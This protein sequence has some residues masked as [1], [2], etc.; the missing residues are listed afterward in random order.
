MNEDSGTAFDSTEHGL[1]ALPDH[2]TN[3]LADV[4]Q[5]VAYENGACGRA[6]VNATTKVPDGN[7]LLVP[8]YDALSIG[9][10]FAVSGWFYASRND[11]NWSKLFS[12]SWDNGG[13]GIETRS[14]TTEKLNFVG[15][16]G[17]KTNPYPSSVPV[18][19]LASGWSKLDC[20]YCGAKVWCYQNGILLT[21]GVIV[22][23]TDNGYPLAFGNNPH[24][25]TDSDAFVGQYDEI[26][27]RGGTLSADRI[28]ADYDMIANR[29]FCTYGKVEGG[30][31]K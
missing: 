4:S 6:R 8:N 3:K 12:R 24:L 29:D 11:L 19:S 28:K 30:A 22:A 10:T 26:R 5:M 15:G 7:F 2:G 17:G 27:L 31:G 18:T 16:G 20:V 21:N 25:K 13:W 23:V 14:K 1:D 9:D